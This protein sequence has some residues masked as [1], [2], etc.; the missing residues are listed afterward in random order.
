MHPSNGGHSDK[1]PGV[2]PQAS[3]P[4]RDRWESNGHTLCIPEMVAIAISPL[5]VDHWNLLSPGCKN[6]DLLLVACW[7][8]APSKGRSHHHRGWARIF[9]LGVP[10]W[11]RGQEGVFRP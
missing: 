9:R 6:S 8:T 3:R 7:P 5:G 2:D 4:C 1:L 11:P 10:P